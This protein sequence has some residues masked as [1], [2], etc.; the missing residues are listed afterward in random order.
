MQICLPTPA[1]SLSYLLKVKTATVPDKL[2]LT[3]GTHMV[4]GE[5][6]L[7]R[8]FLWTS[9]PTQINFILAPCLYFL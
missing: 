6:R 1:P 8:V 3:P 2:S 9:P 4:E 7:Q 5:N